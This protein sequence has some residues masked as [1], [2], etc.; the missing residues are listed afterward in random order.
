M[1]KLRRA[2]KF[3]LA[4]CDGDKHLPVATR[5]DCAWREDDSSDA[6][7][8]RRT[9]STRAIADMTARLS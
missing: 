6:D 5:S 8:W 1:G 4:G 3:V 7:G 9:G 2:I